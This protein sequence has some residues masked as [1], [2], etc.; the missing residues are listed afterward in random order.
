MNI[1]TLVV[2]TLQSNCYILSVE[3]KCLIIDPG[4]EE[5]KIIKHIEKE[6]LTPVGILITHNHNDHIGACNILREMYDIKSYD[7]DNLFE[8]KHFLN[9]FK[10]Q[11]IYTPGHTS[12]SIS[13]YFYEY[14][15][16]FTGD[17]LFKG[18]IG[19]VDFPNSSN[20]DMISSLSKIKTMDEDL[21]I[22]P[23]HGDKTTLKQELKSNQY[24]N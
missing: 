2:G 7:Y 4:A 14:N 8:Q 19:R 16:I 23:G 3:D 15:C 5:N 18:T 13:F 9:P 1:D 10:F 21:I 11:V 12:D 20:V 6:Q 22:Y 24:L 17:F